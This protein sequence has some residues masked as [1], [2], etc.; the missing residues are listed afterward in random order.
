MTTHVQLMSGSDRESGW[1]E[2]EID[3]A[4]EREREWGSYDNAFCNSRHSKQKLMQACFDWVLG[5]FPQT[6]KLGE[7]IQRGNNP[8][9]QRTNLEQWQPHTCLCNPWT[10]SIPGRCPSKRIGDEDGDTGAHLFDNNFNSMQRIWCNGIKDGPLL[11][12]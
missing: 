11:L 5:I 2:R 9:V 12:E 7:G 1:R 4:R 8:C 10:V 6:N 3:W